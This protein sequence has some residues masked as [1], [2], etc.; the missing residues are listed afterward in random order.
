MQLI[1]PGKNAIYQFFGDIPTPI[2]C[3]LV[4]VLF[5]HSVHK[6]SKNPQYNVLPKSRNKCKRPNHN[7]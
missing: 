1:N 2:W 3:P 7:W 6:T 5:E 4:Y